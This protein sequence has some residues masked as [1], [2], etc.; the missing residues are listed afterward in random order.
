VTLNLEFTVT[1]DCA[2]KTWKPS[3]PINELSVVTVIDIDTV[4]L[5]TISDEY[6]NDAEDVSWSLK[7]G[8]F[9]T[10]TLDSTVN[11]SDG[12]L[13]ANGHCGDYM[14]ATKTLSLCPFLSIDGFVL[15]IHATKVAEA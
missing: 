13:A 11:V 6:E 3:K 1:A 10:I 8:K 5:F 15:K 2:T 14:P 9:T 4:N 12:V 7:C